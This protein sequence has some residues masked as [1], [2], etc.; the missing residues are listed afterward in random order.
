MAH[1]T[2]GDSVA[3]SL[4]ITKAEDGPDGTVFVEGLCTDDGLDLDDQVVDRDFAVK[5]LSAWFQ[6]WGA[7]RQ[8]H[9]SNIAPAGKAVKMD[10]R[11]DG[12]WV[13]THVVEPTAVKLVKEG[14]YKAYSVG[15]SKPRI[16]RDPN[17]V[18]KNGRVVDGIFSEI[19]LVDF[20]ANP[21][22]RFQLAKRASS[23]E[24]EIVEKAVEV[25]LTKS[26]PTP[27]DVFGKGGSVGFDEGVQSLVKGG[28]FTAYDEGGFL[29]SGIT[30][31]TNTS[32][33]PIAV[34]K[35]DISDKE[36]DKIPSEDFAGPDGTY[37]IAKP[38][39]VAAAAHLVGKADDP[40]AV[41]A[42]IIAIAKRKGPDF[43]AELP[44]SWTKEEKSA[45][46]DA[47]PVEPEVTKGARDCAGCGKGYHADSSATYCADCGKKL[48]DAPVEKSAEAEVVAPE[49]P[50]EPGDAEAEAAP[51]EKAEE[52]ELAKADA[53]EPKPYH[54]DPDETVKCPKCGKMND[55]DASY[56]DQ[57]GY[58]LAGSTDVTVT[59][60]ATEAAASEAA[61]A[62]AEAAPEPVEKAEGPD[63]VKSLNAVRAE[64]VK[65]APAAEVEALRADLTAEREARETL[66][67]RL[68]EL[69]KSPDPHN[70]AYRGAPLAALRPQAGEAT[71]GRGDAGDPEVLKS[72]IL[73]ARKD[74]TGP[75]AEQLQKAV[76][77]KQAAALIFGEGE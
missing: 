33:K 27:A 32:G 6:D 36:R 25:E 2:D 16:I 77:A 69:E 28:P 10:V 3:F 19:S 39:D 44:E 5:G 57:C 59:K 64:L 34:E 51:V 65:F 35:R 31:V 38:E 41:K 26:V 58:K 70:R 1:T 50:T 4:A 68:A 9:S 14:V 18:A 7:V 8:M 11:E 21:R 48:P 43:V 52:P 54:A 46:T 49:A 56:C 67:K 13:R 76:G 12:V 45:D 20:P 22:A 71:A 30:E 60:S 42:K 61:P 53:Y 62:E 23:G 55:T 29:P 72:I 63:L 37:P 17:G 74:I 73:K 47:A 24:V 75:A 66:E 15:I 40:E